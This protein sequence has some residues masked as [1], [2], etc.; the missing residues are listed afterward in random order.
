MPRKVSTEDRLTAR[1]LFAENKTLSEIADALEGRV[2][3]SWVSRTSRDE[4]WIRGLLP[5]ES[6]SAEQPQIYEH[7]NADPAEMAANTDKLREMNR[8]RWEDQK[9]DLAAKLGAGAARIFEQMFATHV[10][11]EVKTV[12]LGG[13]VQDLRMVEV[14]LAEPTP[15]DKKHLATTLAILVDKASLLSGDATQRVET[16]ALSKEQVTDRLKHYRDELAKRRADAELD[17]A[18][19]SMRRTG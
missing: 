10:V 17:A 7:A 6:L 18:K 14:V 3:A 1:Q 16:S 12:G 9:A 5:P 2:S 8:R 15:A 4:N 19:K 13:G 11:K